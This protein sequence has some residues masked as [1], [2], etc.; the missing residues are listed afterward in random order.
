MQVVGRVHFL[1]A[2]FLGHQV[3]VVPTG[4]PPFPVTRILQYG[5]LTKPQGDESLLFQSAKT[6]SYTATSH[7][8]WQI[9]LEASHRF[10][11]HKGGG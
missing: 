11:R 10:P 4:C 2:A 7:H 8:L 6:K 3:F 9:L 1:I 5:H